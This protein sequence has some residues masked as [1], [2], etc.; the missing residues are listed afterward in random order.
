MDNSSQSIRNTP[1]SPQDSTREQNQ[2]AFRQH[3]RQADKF[4]LEHQFEQARVELA[5]ARKLDPKNPFLIAFEERIAVFE[6]KK[7]TPH[8]QATESVQENSESAEKEPPSQSKVNEVENISREAIEVKLRREIE[9]EY[10][11][12]FT[13]EIRKAEERTASIGEEERSRLEAQRQAI[14][15]KNDQ[16][17]AETRKLLEEEYQQKLGQE[18]SEAEKRLKEQHK[19]E[20]VRVENEIRKQVT[21]EYDSKQRE[22]VARLEHERDEQLEKERQAFSKRE[23]QLKEQFDR[24]MLDALRKNESVFR[25]Q[26]VQQQQLE[27]EE[28]RRELAEEFQATLAKERQS[29]QQETEQLKAKLQ[30]AITVAKKQLQAECEQ[31]VQEQ[32]D[33]IRKREE[34]EFEQRRTRL[35]GEME[36]EFQRKYEDQIAAEHQRLQ[37]EADSA[38][39]QEKKRLQMEFNQLLDAQNENIHK[40]RTDLRAEMEATFLER[41]QRIAEDYGH[42]MDLL[43]AK[44]PTTSEERKALY[45]EKMCSCY[46]NGQPSVDQARTLMQLKEMLELTFDEHMAIESDVRVDLYVKSVEKKVLAGELN[47]SDASALEDLK[48][49]FQ[50]TAEESSRLEPYILSRFQ[51]F[52]TKGKL[53]LVDD[54]LTF[55]HLLEDMLTEAGYQI[56]TAPD[57]K[58][59]L[60]KLNSIPIDLIL[61]DIKFTVGELD[62]FKFF[63]TVQEQP[64]LRTIP[65]VFMSSLQDGVI[66]RS[67]MQLGVDDYLTK[68]MDTDLLVAVIEGKLK[69]YRSYGRN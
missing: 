3:L 20:L 21:D 65:F 18:I 19:A 29:M 38:I 69:R 17:I 63:K 9:E 6:R 22:L 8:P 45:R 13:E 41:L 14:R 36:A 28:L 59:A 55:L 4:I 26:S 51:R 43:G 49:K 5:A 61:S 66:I 47:L 68:P 46:E 12:R 33:Q 7:A 27:R 56:V 62:G 15:V 58:T 44:I 37:K 32:L 39:E 67:G 53:L 48:Q 25:A 40:I 16:Q 23:Q 24:K 57:I 1:S 64:H 60:E 2:Q 52:A 11:G 42:K 31:Q 54:D 50:I 10:K 30:D 35:Q 34:S